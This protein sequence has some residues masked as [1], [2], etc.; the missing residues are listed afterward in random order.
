MAHKVKLNLYFQNLY[1]S[2]THIVRT[3]ESVTQKLENVNVNQIGYQMIAHLHVSNF[4]K[5]VKAKRLYY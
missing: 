4:Q 1:A 5:I 2:M 3:M